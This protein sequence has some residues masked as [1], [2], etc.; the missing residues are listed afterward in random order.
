MIAIGEFHIQPI[1]LED[2]WSVCNYAT[3]NEDRLKHYFPKTLEQNLTPTLSKSFVEKKVS[4]FSSEEELLFTIKHVTS[5]ELVGLVYIKELDK[6]IKQAEFAYAIGYPF[7]GKGIMSKA[8]RALSEYAFE[9]LKLKKLQI[10]V[11]ENNKGS[12]KVA[13]NCGYSWVKTMLN[14]FTPANGTP[15]DMELYELTDER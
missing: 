1:Q 13:L 15:L 11:H 5:N 6:K 3:S 10:I 4:Q 8:V 12:I 7:E 14:E 9:T 2:A